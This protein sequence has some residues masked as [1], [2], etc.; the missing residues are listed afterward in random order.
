M[1]NYWTF[2]YSVVADIPKSAGA[3]TTRIYYDFFKA[4]STVL[5][6][7]DERLAYRKLIKSGPFKLT[8]SVFA[9]GPE[10]ALEWIVDVRNGILLSMGRDPQDDARSVWKLLK[11]KRSAR[12]ANDNNDDDENLESKTIRTSKALSEYTNSGKLTLVM[13]DTPHFLLLVPRPNKRGLMNVAQMKARFDVDTVVV[14]GYLSYRWFFAKPF[15]STWK[16]RVTKFP[17]YRLYKN[18]K[19]IAESKDA[20]DIKR[21]LKQRAMRNVPVAWTSHDNNRPRT[22]K[23]NGPSLVS[24]M[25]HGMAYGVGKRVEKIIP[26]LPFIR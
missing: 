14:P 13:F 16:F 4:L 11:Y 25:A 17:W 3:K 20:D 24:T 5:P 15:S 22:P 12:N 26:P 6:D 1:D 7:K 19:V 8:S 23:K 18:G 10:K 9:E 21:Y 2:L